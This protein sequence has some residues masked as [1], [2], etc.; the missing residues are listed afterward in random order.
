MIRT[1]RQPPAPRRPAVPRKDFGRRARRKQAVV[2]ARFHAVNFTLYGVF[3]TPSVA[4]GPR[5]HAARRALAAAAVLLLGGAIVTVSWFLLRAPASAQ[6][7]EVFLFEELPPAPAPQAPAPDPDPPP[8][9]PV[10]AAVPAPVPPPQFGLQE[11]ALSETG[12]LEVAAGNTL[13]TEAD[14][15]TKAPVAALPPTPQLL[16]QAPR[17]LKGRPPEYPMRALERGLEATVVVLIAIDTLGRVTQVDVERSGGGLFDG[18]VVRAVKALVFQPPVRDGR[19]L[20]ARFR[21]P[22]EFRLE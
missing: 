9:K 6:V 14:T 20:P 15:V 22:Y 18:D 2:P 12:A 7:D 3:A 17:I 4:D 19:R 10:V 5:R 1:L 8:P 11:E 21:Q 16:N 13:M